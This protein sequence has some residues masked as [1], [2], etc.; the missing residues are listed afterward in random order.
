[1]S[2]IAVVRPCYVGGR[3]GM[4]HRWID[5]EDI[6]LK[7]NVYVKSDEIEKAIAK[8]NKTGHVPLGFEMERVKNTYAL[9]EFEDGHMEEIPPTTITFCDSDMYFRSFIWNKEKNDD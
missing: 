3:K 5:K 6:L 2:D 9:I 7:S 1:M 4:F 8:F